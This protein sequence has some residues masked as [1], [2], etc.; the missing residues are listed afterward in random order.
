MNPQAAPT[1]FMSLEEV[2]WGVAVVALTMAIHG[3]GVVATLL[4]GEAMQRRVGRTTVPS[5]IGKLV[6]V[7]W[8]LVTIHLFEVVVWALI[9]RGIDAFPNLSMA[10]Y[11]TLMQYTTVGSDLPVPGRWRLL[12]GMIAIAG[13]LTFAL[14]TSVLFAMAQQFFGSRHMAG[15]RGP[16]DREPG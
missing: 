10:T 5:A 15:W 7:T 4:V 2:S 1:Y 9:L 14:S 13:L 8:L 3:L 12:G 6:V 11:Y 16:V